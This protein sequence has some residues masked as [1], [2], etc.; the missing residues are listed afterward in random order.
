MLP[1]KERVTLEIA[2]MVREDFL[3]QSAYHEVDTFCPLEK[4][5]GMIETILFFEGQASCLEFPDAKRISELDSV[6]RISRMKALPVEEFK[7]EMKSVKDRIEIEF[8]E[9]K[10]RELL[11]K[12]GGGVA[13]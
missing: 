3:Q 12:K 9:L 13:K 8:A 4:Q 5:L 11:A 1:P 7:K 6:R 10:K 2:R